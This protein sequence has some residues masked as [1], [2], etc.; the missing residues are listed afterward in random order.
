MYKIVITKTALKNLKKIPK[1]I[2]INIKNKIYLLSTDP[3]NKGGIKKL[4]GR[5]GYRFRVGDYRVIYEIQNNILVI[6]V[7]NIKSRGEVYK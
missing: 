2:A 1:N 3:Y 4:K 7:I 5:E 6:K